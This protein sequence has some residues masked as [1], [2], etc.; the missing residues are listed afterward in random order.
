MQSSTSAP[1]TSS[2]NAGATAFIPKK[3]IVKTEETFP[4]LD[5]A[6]DTGAKKK[7]APAQQKK[8][9]EEPKKSSDPCHGKPVQFFALLQRNP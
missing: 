9:E 8:K 5:M 3:K 1:S 6:A 7:A 4:T 2:F